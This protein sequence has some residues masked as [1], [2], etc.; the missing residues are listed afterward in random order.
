MDNYVNLALNTEPDK[1]HYKKV[2]ERL[3]NPE[4]AEALKTISASLFEVND[5]L[6]NLKKKVFYGADKDL[7]V[8][9]P[10]KP[11]SENYE[12]FVSDYQNVRLVHGTI[13]I[14]TE[15]VELLQSLIQGMETGEVDVIN[16]L[17]EMGDSRW[18]DAIL[19]DCGSKLSLMTTSEL[20]SQIRE[21]NIAKLS[22]R[23]PEKFSENKATERDL[24]N[25]RK[26]LESTA[27]GK[28]IKYG[29]Q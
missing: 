5:K 3:K 27:E 20:E 1:A 8:N 13:G 29:N 9:V 16:F 24:D 6:D 7:G 11:I 23:Y 21:K 18:Y 22:A 17:E 26:I 4:I 15:A 19:L 25:E 10:V 28:M 12:H 14:V 2:S